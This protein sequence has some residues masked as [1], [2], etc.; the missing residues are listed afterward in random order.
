M[1]CSPRCIILYYTLPTTNI[2]FSFAQPSSNVWFPSCRKTQLLQELRNCLAGSPDAQQP[3]Q[4]QPLIINLTDMTRQNDGS[5]LM[6][7]RNIYN[8]SFEKSWSDLVTANWLKGLALEKLNRLAYC[9]MYPNERDNGTS[10][11]NLIWVGVTILCYASCWCQMKI[12]VTT[13]RVGRLEV[14]YKNRSEHILVSEHLRKGFFSQY[15]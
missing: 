9:Q 1:F 10:L 3:P 15:L 12:I 11:Y 7:V 14:K 8:S 5:I 13:G 2:E 6:S 4:R